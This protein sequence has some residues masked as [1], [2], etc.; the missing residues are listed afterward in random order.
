MS[1][2]NT[3]RHSQNYQAIDRGTL[4]DSAKPHELITILF[5]NA[6]M[7]LDEALKHADRGNL[8]A[9]LQ[10]KSRAST[11]I[12]GLDISLDFDKGGDLAPT[13][14]AIY[15]EAIKLINATSGPAMKDNL[16]AAR[17]I[18]ADIADAWKGIGNDSQAA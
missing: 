13:L 4:V 1:F 14:S 3:A 7:R 17:S 2:M 9:M 5:D 11:I 16:V 10:A 8:P 15:R 18:M 12:S 6:L